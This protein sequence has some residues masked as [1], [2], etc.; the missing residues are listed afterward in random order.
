MSKQER[1]DTF[2]RIREGILQKQE[3]R[4]ARHKR[5][6][7]SIISHLEEAKALKVEFENDWETS[8]HFYRFYHQSYKAYR[9]QG[10]TKKCVKFFEKIAGEE[11]K[12]DKWF[13]QIVDEGTGQIFE[14]SHNQN[15]LKHVRPQI[16][17]MLHAKFFLDLI[18]KYGE[19]LK[20][21]EEPP[22]I[23]NNGWAAILYL[24][25]ER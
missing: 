12:L 4:I 3:E 14:L 19:E 24:F 20:D 25:N 18:V 11:F 6:F 13:L 1:L 2:E 21:E 17:A 10:V 23:L 5:F 16:E 9:A 7:Q 8:N 22:L 15:W